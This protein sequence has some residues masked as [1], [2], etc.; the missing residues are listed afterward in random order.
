MRKIVPCIKHPYGCR[1][2]LM[3]RRRRL[4]Q[5]NRAPRYSFLR[6]L[7]F[8]LHVALTIL[9]CGVW[10]VVLFVWSIINNS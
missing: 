3:T 7:R 10:L 2:S 8:L 1:C 5:F 6:F 4:R 9:T